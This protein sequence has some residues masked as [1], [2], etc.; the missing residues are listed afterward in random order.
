M[1][2]DAP[3]LLSQVNKSLDYYVYVRVFPVNNQTLGSF[4]ILRLQDY[5]IML[6]DGRYWGGELI[7]NFL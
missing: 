5:A 4:I 6:S 7:G 2:I 3:N 1:T